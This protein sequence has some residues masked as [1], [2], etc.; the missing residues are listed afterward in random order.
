M[1]FDAKLTKH[2]PD[3]IQSYKSIACA[4]DAIESH[5]FSRQSREPEICRAMQN[6]DGTEFYNNYLLKVN[7]EGS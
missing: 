1:L 3:L 7:F 4:D 5:W 2:Q 6:I